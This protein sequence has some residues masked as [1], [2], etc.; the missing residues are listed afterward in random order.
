MIGPCSRVGEWWRRLRM[1]MHRGRFERE[2]EEEIRLHVEQRAREYESDGRSASEARSLARSR[3][4]PPLTVLENAVAAWGWRWLDELGQDV[5][6]G[7]RTMRRDAAVTALVVSTLG[8]TIGMATA[9]F[10]VLDAVLLRRLPYRDPATLA[11]LWTANPQQGLAQIGTGYPIVEAWR[12]MNHSFGDLAVASR[13][14]VV[15]IPRDDGVERVTGAVVSA[16]LFSMLGVQPALGRALSTDDEAA[17]RRVVVVS[18]GF[19]KGRWGASP[20]II[21]STLGIDGEP[22]IIVGV[23]PPA[24]QFPSKDIQLWEPLPSLR[25]WEASRAYP[26]SHF[27]MVLGRLRPHA[28]IASARTD[29]AAVGR[30]VAA[31]FPAEDL[32]KNSAVSFD[33]N[34][35][36]LHLQFVDDR[37]RMGVWVL[38]AAVLVVL[39][40][41]CSNVANVLLARSAVRGRELAIRSA[42]GGGRTRLIRQLVTEALL[43]AGLGGG[44]GVGL[45]VVT[46]R[47]FLTLGAASMPRLDETVVDLRVVAFAAAVSVFV[48]LAFGVGP[49]LQASGKS[50]AET[51]KVG[52]RSA[53]TPTGRRLRQLLVAGEFALA[54][55][56]LTASTLLVRS[57]IR[58]LAV[59]TGFRPESVLVARVEYPR[60]KPDA[61]AIAFYRNVI[62]RIERVPGVVAA[63]FVNRFV[64]DTNP[65]DVVT[66]EGR[67]PVA[68]VPLWDDS[69]S[70]GYFRAVGT[71]LL[72]GRFF[73]TRDSPTAPRVAIINDTMARRFWGGEDPLGRRFKMGVPGSTEPWITVVGIVADMRRQGPERAPISQIFVPHEQSPGPGMLREADLLVRLS[74]EPLA[75][76]GL[77]RRTLRDLDPSVPVSRVTTLERQI[78]RWAAP[79]RF[80]TAVLTAFSFVALILAFIGIYG[81]LHYLVAQQTREIGIRIALGAGR[82][83]VVREVVGEGLSLAGAG[84]AA[85]LIG[86]GLIGRVL[87]GQLFGVA[88]TDPVSV[89]AAA[90]ILAA[91]AFAGCLLPALRA[92]SVDPVIVLR[93]D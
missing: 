79:R 26:H 86:V 30:R 45:A 40:I 1:V 13:T 62:D 38:F 3:F 69:V 39:S 20:S 34:V 19:W 44:F 84:A 29:M 49:A 90:A 11:M 25:A 8:V 10:A 15:T 59:D 85:G 43:L 61:A 89:V 46:V 28:T 70:P 52:Q 14:H 63:G 76:E 9:M 41:A 78:E 32:R 80:E 24:F 82:A 75:Y 65:D 35:V 47:V 58:M 37:A 67:R 12:A 93:A 16:N 64:I 77:I 5:R 21:G 57:L 56:L 7:L 71:P 87:R 31:L 51:L 83:W 91:A 36:P 92:T 88:P 73:T 42:L 6:Y 2:L 55:M 68:D 27:W 48:A 22:A 54:L 50:V 72:R 23:M 53:G 18:S 17:H 74:S 81:L 66:I 33:V 60:Q 4:G